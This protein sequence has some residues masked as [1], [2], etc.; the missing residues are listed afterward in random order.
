MAEPPWPQ[1]SPQLG[2]LTRA[3]QALGQHSVELA[4]HLQHASAVNTTDFR[5][6]T[7]VQARPGLTAGELA[8]RLDRSPAATSTVLDRL[9]QAGH[10]ERRPDPDDRRRTTLWVTDRPQRV[11]AQTLRPF[12]AALAGEFGEEDPAELRRTTAHVDRITAVMRAYLQGQ[13][14]NPDGPDPA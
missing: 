9:E 14:T 8:A 4:D 3:I 2:E 7:H 12:V 11:A 6:L 1:V 5:A 13:R 10:V